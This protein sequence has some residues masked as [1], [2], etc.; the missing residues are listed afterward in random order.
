MDSLVLH[1]AALSL[2]N[3]HRI[4][5]AQTILESFDIASSLGKVSPL[6]ITLR[7][8][9]SGVPGAQREYTNR[10]HSHVE[11]P[12][13]TG[14]TAFLRLVSDLR[15]AFKAEKLLVPT[16]PRTD[17]VPP[18]T[19]R[20]PSVKLMR[21]TSL[22]S[23]VPNTKPTM[24]DFKFSRIPQFHAAGTYAAYNDTVWAKDIALEK[25]CISEHWLSDIIKGG[26]VIGEG[27]RS[28]ACVP[29][30]GVPNEICESQDPELSYVKAAK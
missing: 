16:A 5:A 15:A 20:A 24:A 27:F 18:V 1:I 17:R 21:T 11:F 14:L 3:K 9:H 2:P 22:L 30:P 28:I 10:L 26:T 4:S 29:F 12:D 19:N 13:D 7:G 25:I 8:L 23:D 6:L